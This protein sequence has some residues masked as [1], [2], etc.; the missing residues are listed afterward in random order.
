M[1]HVFPGS[2]TP[3]L[4]QLLFPKPPTNF[5]TCFRVER[6]KNAGKKVC[7]NRVS[8]SQLPGHESDTVTTEPNGHEVVLV[9]LQIKK[10]RNNKNDNDL[11]ND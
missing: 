9:Y 4:T 6:R 10:I 7:L 2:L 1:T 8:N 3:V 11:K 5:L